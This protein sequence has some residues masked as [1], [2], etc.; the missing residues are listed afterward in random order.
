MALLIGKTGEAEGMIRSMAEK[1]EHLKESTRSIR[2]IMDVLGN[3][4]KQTNILSLNASIEAARAGAA[5]KGFM[6]VADE[7]RQLAEQSRQSIL[8]VEGI[9]ETIGQEIDATVQTLEDAKPIFQ[10]QIGSVKDANTIFLE[11]QGRMADLTGSAGTV[12]ESIRILD[13]SQQ[14]LSTAINSVSAVA[15]QSSATSRR[16]LR[17][18]SKKLG[19]SDGLVEL[20]SK[21]RGYPEGFSRHLIDLSLNR[22]QIS[23]RQ[24]SEPESIDIGLFLYK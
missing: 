13:E 9:T 3:V 16:L 21:L 4:A 12:L 1:V 23:R 8:V 18:T 5:G 15:E 6:V 17:W 10:E 22:H 20:S 11:V 7:I 19:V 24:T 2:K 14:Q